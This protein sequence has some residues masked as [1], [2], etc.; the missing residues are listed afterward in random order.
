M[1]GRGRKECDLHYLLIT[2]TIV[3]THNLKS[4]QRYTRWYKWI[5]YWMNMN[6]LL[7]ELSSPSR[8]THF[9]FLLFYFVLFL[10]VRENE[11]RTHSTLIEIL[12]IHHFHNWNYLF[13]KF[14]IAMHKKLAK[15]LKS[16]IS[17]CTTTIS[18]LIMNRNK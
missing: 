16:I 2:I 13:G 17:W 18:I 7:K 9:Y 5:T 1:R 4:E 6:G 14:A 10:N 12:Q 15:P 3:R 11:R 8:K